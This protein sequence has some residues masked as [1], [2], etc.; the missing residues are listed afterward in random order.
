MYKREYKSNSPDIPPVLL[1]AAIFPLLSNA[2]APT[3]PVEL[4]AAPPWSNSAITLPAAATCCC[5][6]NCSTLNGTIKYSSGIVCSSCS[7]ANFSAPGP[8]MSASVVFSKTT[9]AASIGF[10][11]LKSFDRFNLLMSKYSHFFN[12]DTPPQAPNCPHISAASISIVPSLVR[13]L[14]R[15]AL[16]LSLSS[17]I[18]TAATQAS[19]AVPPLLRICSDKKVGAIR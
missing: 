3:V 14:P 18:F 7:L 13:T 15:P 16:K 10:L 6:F 5:F 11:M 17:K 2:T 12:N 1:A 8:A 9:R 19:K 4:G